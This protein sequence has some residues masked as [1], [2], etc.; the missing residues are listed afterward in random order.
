VLEVPEPRRKEEVDFSREERELLD[1]KINLIIK[2]YHKK[3]RTR[4]FWTIFWICFAVLVSDSPVTPTSIRLHK[5]G[6][7]PF[8]IPVFW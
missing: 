4:R 3:R 5:S 6:Q 7:L 1:E 8:G 2:K